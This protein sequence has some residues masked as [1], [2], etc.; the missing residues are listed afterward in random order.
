MKLLEVTNPAPF[1]KDVAEKQRKYI[2]T[3][4]YIK[5]TWNR[6]Y[7]EFANI[8]ENEQKKIKVKVNIRKLIDNPVHIL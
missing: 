1:E 3:R 4:A 8:V 6:V 2:K 5:A 7:W